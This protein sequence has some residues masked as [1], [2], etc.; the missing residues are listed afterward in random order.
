MLV[1]RWA[2]A[3][4]GA[5][6]VGVI[7]SVNVSDVLSEPS[8]AVTLRSIEPLK[9][10]GGV[11][12]KVRVAASNESQLGRAAAVGQRRL[13]GQAA[14]HIGERSA[15]TWKVQ[16]VSSGVVWSAI[17]VLTT[18]ASLTGSMVSVNVSETVSEPS[19]A[20]TLSSTVPLKS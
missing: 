3:T 13:V 9:S 12:E 20:V 11:P 4:T 1:A 18:G 19:L 17:G 14:V 5:S 8:L 15:G 7:V 6:L 16:A 10:S 2:S